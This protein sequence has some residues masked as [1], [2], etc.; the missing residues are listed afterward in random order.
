MTYDVVRHIGIIDIGAQGKPTISQ[1]G[2]N[3]DG[4]LG[5]PKKVPKGASFKAECLQKAA[6]LLQVKSRMVHRQPSFKNGSR[7]NFLN[8]NGMGYKRWM[9]KS[10]NDHL[11]S[12]PNPCAPATRRGDSDHPHATQTSAG[13]LGLAEPQ[14]TRTSAG[15]GIHGLGQAPDSQGPGDSDQRQAT[16][17]SVRRLAG[18][19]AG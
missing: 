18:T 7:F 1:V 2:E 15:P 13:R 4:G 11:E 3:P 6:G 12:S 9:G 19:S 10:K 17:S 5:D 8:N 16:Q 14:T